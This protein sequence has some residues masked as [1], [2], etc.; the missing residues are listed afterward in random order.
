VDAYYELH[1]NPWDHAAG[2]LVAAEAGL[3]VAGLPGRP[4]AEPMAIVSAPSIAQEFLALVA[5]LHPE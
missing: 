5:A 1:L 2:A 3:V 4:F